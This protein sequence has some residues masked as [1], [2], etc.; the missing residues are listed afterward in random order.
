M[1]DKIED[2]LDSDE[3]VIWRG[4]PDNICFIIFNRSIIM[5]VI[6]NFIWFGT[7]NKTGFSPLNMAK[8]FSEQSGGV[9]VGLLLLTP[10]Y[11]LVFTLIKNIL[12]YF[13][14]EYAYTDK[15]IIIR[16]GVIGVDISIVEYT[17]VNDIKVN[18]SLI[19]KFLNVGTVI[20]DEEWVRS[21]DDRVNINAGKDRFL[22]IKDPYEILKSFKTVAFDIKTDIYYPNNLRPDINKG[23]K[24]GKNEK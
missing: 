1:K 3:T 2:I 11:L 17:K 16:R 13:V 24:G 9:I 15:R 5:M 23:Y 14:I 7:L 18:I 21:G 19:E 20:F 8:A 10:L 22:Y 4:K 6:F 12:E